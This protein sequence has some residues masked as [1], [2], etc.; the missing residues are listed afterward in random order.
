LT[1]WQIDPE[2]SPEN[3]EKDRKSVRSPKNVHIKIA[4]ASLCVNYIHT[5]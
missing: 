2:D 4:N 5:I 1:D 3:L